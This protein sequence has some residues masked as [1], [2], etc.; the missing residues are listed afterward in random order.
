MIPSAEL[1]LTRSEGDR[2]L[3]VL[4]GVGTLRREGLFARSATAEAGSE[5]WRFARVGLW[6]R[7]IQAVDASGSTVGEFNRREWRGGGG[8]EWAGRVYALRPISVLR[9]RYALAGENGELARVHA[10]GWGKRPVGI[11]VLT[12][13]DPGLLLFAAYVSDALAE[14]ASAAAGA[15]ASTGAIGG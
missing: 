8:I 2:R 4:A 15:G 9:T 13:V 12:A 11:S 7:T 3:Y 5:R 10:K 14:D 6:G 1:E